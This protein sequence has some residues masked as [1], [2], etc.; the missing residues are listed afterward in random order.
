[1][2]LAVAQ[3]TLNSRSFAKTLSVWQSNQSPSNLNCSCNRARQL[4]CKISTYTMHLKPTQMAWLWQSSS[5]PP[6]S[7]TLASHKVWRPRNALNISAT[8]Q[9]MAV[10]S[11]VSQLTQK[12]V[13]WHFQMIKIKTSHISLTSWLRP[14]MAIILRIHYLWRSAICTLL[15][16]SMFNVDLRRSNNRWSRRLS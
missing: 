9:K 3:S 8:S 15:S 16:L 12:R 10:Q 13:S 6:V 2:S 7:H 5:P 11:R 1:M 4:L 14:L